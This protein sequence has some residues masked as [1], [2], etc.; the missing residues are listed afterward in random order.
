MRKAENQA[1]FTNCDNSH[2]S[3]KRTSVF[4]EVQEKMNKMLY[5][6]K[7]DA[8]N[9]IPKK[10]LNKIWERFY[11]SDLSRGKDKKGTGLGLAIVK[12]VIQ[13]HD[14]HINVIS[15]EGVGTEFIFSLSKASQD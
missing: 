8:G 14:E 4:V 12:E 7:K 2:K 5:V 6:C 10:E 15:T 11:K 1:V 13:A 9:G 3:A